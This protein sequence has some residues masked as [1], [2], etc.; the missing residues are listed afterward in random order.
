VENE[1]LDAGGMTSVKL[2]RNAAF[3]LGDLGAAGRRTLL[4]GLK[5]A[6][7]FGRVHS[8]A[9]LESLVPQDREVIDG[10]I[11]ALGDGEWEVLAAAALALREIDPPAREAA[12]ALMRLLDDERQEVRRPVLMAL[13]KIGLSESATPG[14][15]RIVAGDNETPDDRRWAAVLLGRIGPGAKDGVSALLG[16][17]EADDLVLRTEAIRALG[18]IGPEAEKAVAGLLSS[19]QPF[20]PTQVVAREALVRIGPAAVRG[21]GTA[22]EDESAF[23]RSAAAD[24]LGSFG[25][26]AAGAVHGLLAALDDE[27]SFVRRSAAEALGKIG[28]GARETVPALIRMLR[29]R[30]AGAWHMRLTLIE[31]LGR[32]GPAA[33]VAV[34]EIQ[35][36]L[37]DPDGDIRAEAVLALWR[38]GGDARLA[39]P[40]LEKALGDASVLVRSFSAISLLQ[41]G[42]K[43]QRTTD[44]LLEAL[45]AGDCFQR[46][47]A[48]EILRE[49]R[50]ET[51][52]VSPVLA[53]ALSD[54]D[55]DDRARMAARAS[56]DM[57]DAEAARAVPTARDSLA[58]GAICGNVKFSQRDVIHTSLRYRT[59]RVQ[60]E[61]ERAR[62]LEFLTGE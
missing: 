25:A 22:L 13:L 17:L 27:F 55:D 46:A 57:V 36:A 20:D 53:G 44:A 61:E 26:G 59:R 37:A 50:L 49:S 29:S 18:S 32:I 7:P 4:G 12:P 40:L 9:G 24:T 58:L 45:K 43:N 19:L 41:L 39:I 47:R 51:E 8:L 34:A 42:V 6:D 62:F 33:S 16:L 60:T 14:L 3:A 56:P 11:E 21:L 35:A 48:A 15:T 23:V 28:P 30:D 1:T 5:H 2:R 38:V 54:F 10:Y 31:A 52:V